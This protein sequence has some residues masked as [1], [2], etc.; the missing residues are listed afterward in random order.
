MAEIHIQKKKK[1]V[2]P[3]ILAAVVVLAI[4]LWIVVDTDNN[5]QQRQTAVVDQTEQI[6]QQDAFTDQQDNQ[7]TDAVDD[8][9]SFV[10]ESNAREE[11]DLDH[12]YTAEGISLLSAALNDMVNQLGVEDVDMQQKRDNLNRKAD[13]IQQDPASTQHA[14]TIRSAFISSADIMSNLQQ[15][16]FPNLDGEVNN[17]RETAQAVDPNTL[18]L[19]QKQ[20]VKAF[21]SSSAQALHEMT[22]RNTEENN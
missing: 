20:N 4:I 13:Q 16:H 18:T 6:Q 8:F 11:M 14:D 21:F 12:D 7:R 19:E 10:Q 2:W 22:N 3:W 9:I 5:D 1:P 17:V 15:Q